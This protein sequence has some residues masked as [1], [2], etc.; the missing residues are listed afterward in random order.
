M[1]DLHEIGRAKGHRCKWDESR[2]GREK[3]PWLMILPGS[4]GH[5]YVHG[6]DQLAFATSVGRA[7]NI[8]REIE[9]VEFL[10]TGDD[11]VNATSPLDEF[12]HV[13]K[14]LRLY[15]KA[16]LNLTDEQKQA[17]RE[18]LAKSMGRAVPANV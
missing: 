5:I 2:V 4:W 10:Q 15:R 3:D 14:K 11:G 16:T 17:I 6:P 8:Q 1:I 13:A 9:G 7:K 12:D 18:R